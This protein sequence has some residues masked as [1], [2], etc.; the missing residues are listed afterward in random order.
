MKQIIKPHQTVMLVLGNQNIDKNS[1]YRPLKYVY[2]TEID[3]GLLIS[4]QL[5]S[6]IV[7]LNHYEK[8]LY[9][10]GEY[11]LLE[12]DL[13]KNW[14]IVPIDFDD[15]LL[16]KQYMQ[17]YSL[18]NS[19]PQKDDYKQGITTYTIFTTTDCN[20]RCF[21][22]F[23][24]G[25]TKTYMSEQTALDL[26]EFIVQHCDGK[27]VLLRWF[28]GEPL[29]N[30]EVIDI[31]CNYLTE[32][33]VEFSSRMITNGYLLDDSVIEK[34]K[35]I[36]NLDTLQITLDGTEKV[37]NKI[38]NYIYKDTNA[39]E[40]VNENIEKAL[41]AGFTVHIRLNMDFHNEKDLYELADYLSAKYS[42]YEKLAVYARLL[43]EVENEFQHTLEEKH[44]LIDKF[45]SLTEYL[46]K[47]GLFRYSLA[48]GSI[49]LHG[50]MAGNDHTATV[51]TDG[52]LG[53]CESHT[54][55][56]DWGSI[57]TDYV[58]YGMIDKYRKVRDE[59]SYCKQCP[60]LPKCVQTAACPH[61]AKMCDEADRYLV[62]YQLEKRIK[63]SYERY[64]DL[65]KVDFKPI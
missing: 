21:Y 52:R 14:F 53:K 46:Y 38:K 34:A 58:D 42:D 61:V 30:K 50:C 26:A 28:G 48:S 22:C 6:E 1:K 8:I 40:I 35:M 12:E 15:Y 44:E 23:E 43:F 39:F 17:T 16:Y 37:Y 33:K 54:E 31:I 59:F 64:K 27:K 41:K 57:Y 13:I 45:I 63:L 10:L 2:S 65:Y 3:D 47:K 29:Y 62:L 5:T 24:K 18:L 19:R 25:C 7:F 32:K 20:A 11:H 51:M 60:Y 36:W 49:K 55:T 56:E 9:K 4:N